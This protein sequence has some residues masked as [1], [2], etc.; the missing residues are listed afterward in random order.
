VTT[1]A[2]LVVATAEHARAL[3]TL[4]RPEE[5]L[6]LATTG[7]EDPLDMMLRGIRQGDLTLAGVVDGRVGAMVGAIDPEPTFLGRR[8]V[9]QL[10]FLTGTPFIES[11]RP[12]LRAARRALALLHD[13]Y[14]VMWNIIDGR[15]TGALR[16]AAA[17]GAEFH[18]PVPVGPARVPFV[19]FTIR[20]N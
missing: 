13:I 15:Y 20:R 9:G 17:M 5:R 18:S 6:E 16:F 1:E 4:L 12:F 10:W 3:A 19:P 7:I 2:E 14:P 11:P 8:P